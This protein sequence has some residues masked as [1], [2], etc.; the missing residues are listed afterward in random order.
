MKHPEQ[1]SAAPE[2][3]VEEYLAALL[4]EIPPLEQPAFKTP[5][6]SL[7]VVD[8]PVA[9][10]EIVPEIT[11][12]IEKAE[13]ANDTAM[14]INVNANLVAGEFQVLL[15]NVSGISLA[16]PLDK[17]N[18]ILE[19]QALS[20]MPNRSPCFLGLRAER[21][22]QIKVIDT[23]LIVVP[24]KFRTNHCVENLTKVILVGNSH[25]GLA[26]DDIAEVITLRQRD[27]RWRGDTSKR[28]WLAGTVIEH[29]CALVDVEEFVSMMSSDALTIAE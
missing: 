18:G 12:E 19:W 6:T 5:E 2:A 9:E 15:F 26:C 10:P 14:E 16:V 25:W 4:A 28:P 29:M 24:A 23:A 7:P 21:D 20:P 3:V 17:L 27:V 8:I 13:I 1:K 22:K 11:P